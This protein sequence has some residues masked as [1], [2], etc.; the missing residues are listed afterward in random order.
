MGK[1]LVVN[2]CKKGNK[3]CGNFRENMWTLNMWC[4]ENRKVITDPQNIPDWCPLQ[5]SHSG[6]C[7]VGE[8]DKEWITKVANE[9]IIKYYGEFETTQTEKRLGK[10]F[11]LIQGVEK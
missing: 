4:S 9:R 8:E 11:R 7:I 6:D 2:F 3:K 1:I 10:M 5:E